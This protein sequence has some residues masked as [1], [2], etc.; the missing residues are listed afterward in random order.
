MTDSRRQT[1]RSS[2]RG[3]S[4]LQLHV[5]PAIVLRGLP[6]F[7]ERLPKDLHNSGLSIGTFGKYLKTLLFSAS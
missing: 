6:T 7:M 5:W 3:L 1:L 2:G 4:I